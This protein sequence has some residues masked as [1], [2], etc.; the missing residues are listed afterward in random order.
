MEKPKEPKEDEILAAI[1]KIKPEDMPWRKPKPKK[2]RPEEKPG[3]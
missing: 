2:P 1:L 3:K